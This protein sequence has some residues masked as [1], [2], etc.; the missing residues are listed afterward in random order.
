MFRKSSPV[1]LSSYLD[2]LIL[3]S[4]NYSNL[5]GETKKLSLLLENCGFKVN[6]E[7][8]IMDPSKTIEHLGYKKIN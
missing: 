3:I 7:K 4:D 8:S 6:K 5:R 1:L 2:D